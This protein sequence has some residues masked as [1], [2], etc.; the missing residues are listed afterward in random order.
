MHVTTRCADAWS[1][2]GNDSVQT[3]ILD[4]RGTKRYKNHDPPQEAR[5]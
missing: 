3:M 4:V 1:L 5:L 2:L